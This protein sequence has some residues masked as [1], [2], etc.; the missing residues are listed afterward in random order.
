MA[1]N[2][3]Y[4]VNQALVRLVKRNL[5]LEREL[6]LL[7]QLNGILKDGMLQMNH[8]GA[9]HVPQFTDS[10]ASESSTKKRP[11]E[12]MAASN[13]VDGLTTPSSIELPPEVLILPA[14]KRRKIE[15]ALRLDCEVSQHF[16]PGTDQSPHSSPIEPKREPIVPT[17]PEEKYESKEEQEDFVPLPQASQLFQEYVVYSIG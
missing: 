16:L 7:K 12:A 13:E 10:G 8:S 9:S 17:P 5:H 15:E 3:E 2:S 14:E 6:E 1:D 4:L 11:R